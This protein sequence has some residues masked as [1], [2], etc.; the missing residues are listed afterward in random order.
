MTNH[1]AYKFLQANTLAYDVLQVLNDSDHAL[2]FSQ[3]V[4]LLPVDSRQ[5]MSLLFRLRDYHLVD[6][7]RTR[8]NRKL[9]DIPAG[10]QA[11]VSQMLSQHYQRGMQTTPKTLAEVA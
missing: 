11:N 4:E 9:W 10:C 3:I 1:T 7:T 8:N 2:L 5:V 6:C